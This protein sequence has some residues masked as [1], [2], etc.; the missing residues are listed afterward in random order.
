[1]DPVPEDAQDT[2]DP[3]ASTSGQPHSSRVAPRDPSTSSQQASLEL[4]PEDSQDT[5]DPR[6]ST[7]SQPHSSQVTP[8]GLSI[9]SQQAS[10]ELFPE[11][12][13]DTWD[14]RASTS[15]QPHSSQVTPGGPS[16]SSQQA[17]LELF[18]EDSQD[19]WD[20]RA[21]TSSDSQSI[22]Q[23][24][25]S[26]EEDSDGGDVETAPAS[27]QGLPPDVNMGDLTDGE[28]AAL[29]TVRRRW[30]SALERI[31]EEAREVERA[32]QRQHE[33]VLA[34]LRA[35]YAGDREE[36]RAMHQSMDT[37]IN[38]IVDLTHAV[39]QLVETIRLCAPVAEPVPSGVSAAGPW[40]TRAEAR[41]AGL[42]GQNTQASG[43]NER[44]PWKMKK[45]QP[46]TPTVGGT[47]P[48][49]AGSELYLSNH[50]K[51]AHH[52]M[53]PWLELPCGL[54][55]LP[56]H[57]EMLKPLRIAPDMGDEGC[58]PFLGPWVHPPAAVW[59]LHSETE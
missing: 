26:E 46:Y 1:M 49:G 2:R 23:Q 24:T 25:S 28:R 55:V 45:T 34:E 56:G 57:S 21:S 6:A 13:Q 36:C 16:I 37:S 50:G 15:S 29:S 14:P 18:P 10:L 39:T 54:C 38:A 19:T 33:E 52:A 35:S 32:E 40:A 31:G 53:A 59:A 5:W 48:Q 7:S 27:H 43:N 41:Q 17:S 44:P 30:V 58:P 12:S 22:T 3:R 11:D 9:S 20:P 8:G 51:C 47:V 4:F 42:T